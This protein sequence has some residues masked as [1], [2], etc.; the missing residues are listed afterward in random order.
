M[1]STQFQALSDH[2][3]SQQKVLFIQPQHVTVDYYTFREETCRVDETVYTNF[4][5][6]CKSSEDVLVLPTLAKPNLETVIYKLMLKCSR[7]EA[8]YWL[9]ASDFEQMHLIKGMTLETLSQFCPTLKE[10]FIYEN[11]LIQPFFS[12]ERLENSQHVK[13]SYVLDET[14][15]TFRRG[16]IQNFIEYVEKTDLSCLKSFSFEFVQDLSKVLP[17]FVAKASN[18]EALEV[19]TTKTGTTV[20]SREDYQVLSKLSKMK[21]FKIRT[22]YRLDADCGLEL[23]LESYHKLEKFHMNQ[24]LG[25]IWFHALQVCANTNARQTLEVFTWYSNERKV[26]PNIRK[27]LILTKYYTECFKVERP[28]EEIKFYSYKH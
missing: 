21:M 24:P 27:N 20:L 17:M 12:R 28:G 4:P 14:L 1:V 10:V 7:L 3:W 25:D 23:L 22:N 26:S 18:L 11:N 16:Q 19:I 8:I 2:H 15:G 6:Y 9:L 13:F 5:I